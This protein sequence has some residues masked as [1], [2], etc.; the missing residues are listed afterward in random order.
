MCSSFFPWPRPLQLS[1]RLALIER[2]I[3][4]KCPWLDLRS[5]AASQQLIESDL[6]LITIGLIIIVWLRPCRKCKNELLLVACANNAE[7]CSVWSDKTKTKKRDNTIVVTLKTITFNLL[8]IC[9]DSFGYW[10]VLQ[11]HKA[12]HSLSLFLLPVL[13]VVTLPSFLPPLPSPA[14]LPLRAEV[15]LPSNSLP[16]SQNDIIT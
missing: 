14:C 8:L 11:T 10:D 15:T 4:G 16:R 5:G 13:Y 9:V 6:G 7:I 3:C 1:P 2:Q 12:Q